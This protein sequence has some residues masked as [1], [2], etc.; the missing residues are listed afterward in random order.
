MV[1]IVHQPVPR[2]ASPQMINLAT[3]IDDA[4]CY[5][6]IRHYRWPE[7]VRCTACSS[8]AVI[9]HGHDERHRQ[10]YRCKDCGARF[11]DLT[12]TILAGHHQPLR[13]WV[14]C[15]YFMG[16]NLSNQQIARELGLNDDDVHD[17][18]SH[19]REG[20]VAK[21]PEATLDGEVEADEVYVVAGHKGN[22]AAVQKKDRVGRRRRLKGARGRGTL[23]KEKPPI[24]GLIQRNGQVILRMLP[25]V[26]Q[27]TIKPIIDAA[28]AK[29]TMIYTDEYDI[30]ARLPVWGYQHKTVCH[31]RGEYARDEDGDG[32]HEVHVNTLE[33]FWSL[34]RS[35]LRPHRGISQEKL[36]I[37]LGFFQFVHN[38]RKRGKAL[39]GS[40][41]GALVA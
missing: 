29:G 19:L 7:G 30:Y 8:T 22:P 41:V 36:P 34:L 38:T 15:L 31:S 3:L 4:K 33:G 6:L 28:V 12:G 20:L 26:K 25:D 18:A 35:W 16:L 2:M 9:R 32:F 27:K 13:V 40:L 24:L 5:E 1:G 37:Y 11:D 17:M 14:L 23:E 21:V 39:L 10:R